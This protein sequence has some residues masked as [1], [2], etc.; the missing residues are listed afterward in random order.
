[1]NGLF[2]RPFRKTSNVCLIAWIPSFH[3]YPYDKLDIY[4][5]GSGKLRLNSVGPFS[6]NISCFIVPLFCLFFKVTF[7]HHA[8]DS[9][10]Y[11]YFPKY[12]AK[13]HGEWLL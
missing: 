5:S 2:A 8:V 6:K 13:V 11:Q 4:L 3:S 12:T 9:H 10:K 1:M 7:V